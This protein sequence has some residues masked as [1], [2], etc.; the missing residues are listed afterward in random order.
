MT[1]VT[2]PLKK[3]PLPLT[4]K[5]GSISLVLQNSV[6]GFPWQPKSWPI[7][8]DITVVTAPPF[9]APIRKKYDTIEFAEDLK[10]S[11]E[12]Y[13]CHNIKCCHSFLPP[14]PP[15]PPPTFFRC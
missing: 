11:D 8:I 13:K 3:E 5:D 4:Y 10:Q 1:M 9:V 7:S 12:N 2:E 15:S 6:N 14:P